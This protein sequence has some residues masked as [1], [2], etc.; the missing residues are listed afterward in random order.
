MLGEKHYDRALYLL[1]QMPLD[2]LS[3]AQRWKA[4]LNVSSRN[5]M[6]LHAELKKKYQPSGDDVYGMFKVP[7]PEYVTMMKALAEEIYNSDTTD[8]EVLK[9]GREAASVAANFGGFKGSSPKFIS[10]ELT[11][12]Y[13]RAVYRRAAMT[14]VNTLGYARKDN[15]QQ[16]VEAIKAL[17]AKYG[18]VETDYVENNRDHQRMEQ[19]ER[20]Q[21]EH[22]K[23]VSQ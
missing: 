3:I 9:M 17:L 23:N 6:E 15:D 8:P 1:E 11:L 20:E 18:I 2:T 7:A 13:A 4:M 22:M 16:K 21:Q 10:S 19:D 12:R 14:L 5:A